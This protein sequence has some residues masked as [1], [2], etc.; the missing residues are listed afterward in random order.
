MIA[1]KIKNITE[2]IHHLT[3]Q[4]MDQ[5]DNHYY[6]RMAC[7]YGVLNWLETHKI[8][9]RSENLKSITEGNISITY[10]EHNTNPQTYQELYKYYLNFLKGIPPIAAR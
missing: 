7:V 4:N 8:I 2:R 6:G 3:E 1:Y 10:T 9:N 5:V